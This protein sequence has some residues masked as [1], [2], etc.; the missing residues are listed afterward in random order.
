MITA[1]AQFLLPLAQAGQGDYV[2]IAKLVFF[3]LLITPWIAA[4]PWVHK[5]ARRSRAQQSL[6]SLVTFASGAVGVLAWL[7]IPVYAVGLAAFVLL[8]AGG[9]AAYVVARNKLVDP[10][11]RVLTP[12]H[13]ASLLGGKKRRKTVEVVQK[14]KIY[15]ADRAVG[16]TL[17]PGQS[18]EDI[19]AHNLVQEFVYDLVWRRASE[20]EL[21]PLGQEARVRFVVDGVTED[22][23]RLALADSEAIINFLKAPAGM[24]PQERRRPQQGTISVDL[25]QGHTDIVLTTAGTTGGQRMQFRVLREAV[26]TSLD[27]L[28]M[29]ESMLAKVRHMLK[30]PS[31]LMFVAA[32]RGNGQ[33]STL[34]S[35]LRTFDAFT[36]QL[37]TLEAK[38]AADLDNITQIP[39]ASDG[40]LPGAL[41]AALRRDPDVL[42]V[43][44]CPDAET[45]KLIIQ[46]AAAKPV[47]VGVRAGDSFVALAKW[48]KAAGD[49]SASVG[50]L[51][52]VLCQVLV[53]KLCQSCR[54]PYRPDP[55]MLAKLNLSAAKVDRFYRPPT[56]PVVDG[57]GN[58]IVCG[59]CQGSGYC[60]RTAV[61]ELLEMTPEIRSLVNQAAQVAQIKAACRKNKMLYIQE[62]ALHRV[63]DGTTGIQEIVR[64][65]QQK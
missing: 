52:G 18:P 63:L 43:D 47:L 42:M 60:G 35:M 37:V 1:T 22:R 51:K 34:Y 23:P 46:T 38:P 14:L 11:D 6:W 62:Q 15:S 29:P 27:S 25:A 53:R 49:A 4:L 45:A 54:E 36:S 21:T 48:I 65:S 2:S 8:S 40:E 17:K 9:L 56:K 13:L 3:L 57:K 16:I 64:L 12:G 5:D 41:A 31:G 59:N 50:P 44:Q 20:G 32:P 58:T 7:L 10:E 19:K 24:N 26:Q 55:Q 30:E 33:T 39:Y 61:F 28:G